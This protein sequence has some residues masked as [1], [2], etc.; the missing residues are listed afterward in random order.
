MIFAH[1]YN[2][3]ILFKISPSYNKV[4]RTYGGP[5]PNQE[6]I[7]PYQYNGTVYSTCITNGL[8]NQPWCSTK[9]DSNENHVLGKWGYCDLG[10]PGGLGN[11]GTS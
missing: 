11:A 1:F 3:K 4:C 6:C 5:E 10:C 2:Y 7:F 9:V 8:G